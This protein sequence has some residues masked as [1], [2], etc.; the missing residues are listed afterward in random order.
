MCKFLKVFAKHWLL[1]KCAIA[2]VLVFAN[3]GLFKQAF[4]S[5]QE[6]ND[7]DVQNLTHLTFVPATVA[8]T[9]SPA[10]DYK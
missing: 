1:P 7:F 2:A 4:D 9:H 10:A 6:S 5:I 3:I 8:K